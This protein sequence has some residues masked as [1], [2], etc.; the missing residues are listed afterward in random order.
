M[1]VYISHLQTL[2]SSGKSWWTYP[3]VGG[4]KPVGG[5]GRGCCACCRVSKVGVDIRKQVT[6]H[7][8]HTRTHVFGRE[9]REMP[10]KER[11]RVLSKLTRNRGHQTISRPT[12]D[13][14]QRHSVEKNYIAKSNSLNQQVSCV[15]DKDVVFLNLNLK[16]VT[17]LIIYLQAPIGVKTSASFKK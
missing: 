15:N 9:T 6:H 8:W 12:S 16:T 1:N 5:R 2:Y 3:K 17:F 4:S 11:K 7:C 14:V 13:K 10:A